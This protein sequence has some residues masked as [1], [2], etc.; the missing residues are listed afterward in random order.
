MSSLIRRTLRA[1]KSAIGM[2]LALVLGAPVMCSADTMG[3]VISE[4]MPDASGVE[5]S[6][7]YVELLATRSIDFSTN[8]YSVVFCSN[9]SSSSTK[10]TANGW[11]E[12]KLVTYGFSI[13]SGTVSAGDVIYVGGAGMAPTGRTLRTIDLMTSPG[14]GFGLVRDYGGGALGN[15]GNEADCLAVFDKPIGELTA[16]TIPIDAIFFGTGRGATVV[17][18]GAEGYQLPVNDLYSGGKFNSSSFYITQNPSE[19]V[20]FI[21]SGMYDLASGEWTT[22]RT[23]LNDPATDGTSAIQLAYPVNDPTVNPPPP[24]AVPLPG[25][26]WG[27]MV[28]MGVVG[29]WRARPWRKR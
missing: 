21:A 25:A 7:E 13:T 17:S 11:V 19:G 27:G 16:G 22:K 10:A 12:G 9:G 29:A 20:P 6:Q 5:Y 4:F 2:V 18:G 24:T 26:A 15:G 14:D 3:L 23:F 1:P 28:L 8:P